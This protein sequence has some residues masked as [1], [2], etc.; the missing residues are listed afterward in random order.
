MLLLLLLL[1]LCSGALCAVLLYL[2]AV[3]V[4]SGLRVVRCDHLWQLLAERQPL[5]LDVL[6]DISLD[7]LLIP[8][9]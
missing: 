6:S 2:A 8:H 9:G 7:P 4:A 3:L 1:P 5:Y